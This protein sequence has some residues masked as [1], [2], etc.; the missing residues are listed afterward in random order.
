[1]DHPEAIAVSTTRQHLRIVE[2]RTGERFMIVRSDGLL[3][4]T[5]L[6]NKNA[7]TLR[8]EGTCQ[9]NLNL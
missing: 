5:I 3:A 9:E 8:G 1:M 4:T 2:I 6:I 7:P